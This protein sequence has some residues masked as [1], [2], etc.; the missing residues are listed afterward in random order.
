MSVTD[1]L[2]AVDKSAGNSDA[3]FRFDNLGLTLVLLAL[4]VLFAFINPR[5]ATVS[6]MINVLTQASTWIIVA[7][8]MTFVI[9]KGGID[10]SVGAAM[11]LST[12]V[13]FALLDDDASEAPTSRVGLMVENAKL[14][15]APLRSADPKAGQSRLRRSVIPKWKLHAGC[16]S[17]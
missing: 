7:V 1:S 2:G 3:R 4:I 17:F 16:C 11:A 14:I 15:C 5:F 9:T 10:L 6:N 12:S 8:G 13:T